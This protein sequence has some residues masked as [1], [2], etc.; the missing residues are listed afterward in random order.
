MGDDG[1]AHVAVA[2]DHVDHAPGQ[3]RLMQD[4]DQSLSGGGRRP[5]GLEDDRAAGGEQA[6]E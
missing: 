6:L 4:G 5:G 3:T 2:D 1:A